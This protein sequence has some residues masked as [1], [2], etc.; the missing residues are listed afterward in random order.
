MLMEGNNIR[1]VLMEPRTALTAAHS[2]PWGHPVV[3][4]SRPYFLLVQIKVVPHTCNVV[5]AVRMQIATGS[6]SC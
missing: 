5:T 4:V 6:F 3:D 1:C 2:T